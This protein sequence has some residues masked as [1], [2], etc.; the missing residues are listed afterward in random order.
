VRN[1]KITYQQLIETFCCRATNL[2]AG[3]RNVSQSTINVL[4]LPE[5]EK[6]AGTGEKSDEEEPS[7]FSQTF[8]IF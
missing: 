6:S 7:N 3:G 8:A 1:E 2:P 4:V 5:A